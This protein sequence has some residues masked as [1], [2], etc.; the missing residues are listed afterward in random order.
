[1]KEEFHSLL[2]NALKSGETG[3]FHVGKGSLCR[4]YTFDGKAV[5]VSTGQT[6][7]WFPTAPELLKSIETEELDRLLESWQKGDHSLTKW[8]SVLLSSLDNNRNRET[9]SLFIDE[10]VFSFYF[11]KDGFLFERGQTTSIPK[12]ENQTISLSAS[13]LIQRIDH[14]SED[15]VRAIDLF[16]SLD[17]VL[18]QSSLGKKTPSKTH[19]WV[20][21]RIFDLVDGFRDLREIIS[22]SPFVPHITWKVLSEG[23]QNG[24]LLKKRLPEFDSCNPSNLNTKEQ[25]DLLDQLQQALPL[26]ANP[27]ALLHLTASTLQLLGDHEAARHTQLKIIESH[28]ESKRLKEAIEVLDEVS[29]GDFEKA[30]LAD[31]RQKLVIELAEQYLSAGDLDLG[32]RWLREAIDTSDDDQIRLDLIATYKNSSDQ[33]R[34]GTRI[35]TRL[36]RSGQKRRALRLMDSLEALHPEDEEMQ[37]LRLEFLID[38]GEI[39]ASEEALKRMASRLANEGRINRARKVAR[40]LSHLKKSRQDTPRNWLPNLLRLLPRFVL[41]V[42]FVSLVSMVILAESRLQTLITSAE[43]LPPSDWQRNARP[44]LILLPDGP[45]KSGLN[46]AAALVAD[47]EKNLAHDYASQRAQILA[48]ARK[49]RRLG[50]HSRSLDLLKS[51]ELQGAQEESRSLR[52]EWEKADREATQLKKSAEKALAQGDLAACHQFLRSLILE[53]P[54]HDESLNLRFPVLVDSEPGTVVHFAGDQLEVPA[55]ILVHPFDTTKLQLQR[56]GRSAEYVITAEGPPMRFL[57]SP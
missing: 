52:E 24:K 29:T 33:I 16:P 31:L 38:H 8:M 6:L 21:H 37:Q 45:W 55:L 35:A 54:A 18:I 46:T 32:R 7:N 57:P 48:D 10:L 4:K 36:Y 26:A 13:D 19:S 3:H 1:M 47:R 51:A 41:I 17:E 5:H 53:H 9:N 20:S 23:L 27:V 2:R 30:D 14:I 22:S 50:L 56:A 15:L 44:W 39:E 28:R 40:S 49:Y 11:C 42:F 12:V 43:T 34:E 25:R